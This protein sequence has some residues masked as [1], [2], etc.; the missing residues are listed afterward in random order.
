M[1]VVE[2]EDFLPRNVAP[3]KKSRILEL[4]DGSE[5]EHD[6]HCL[7]PKNVN[8]EDNGDSNNDEE[9]EEAEESAEAELGQ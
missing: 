3:K 4:S 6:V 9:V 7:P 8:D 2:D 1:E 5:D